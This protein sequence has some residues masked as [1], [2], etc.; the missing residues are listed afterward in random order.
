MCIKWLQGFR[1]L[2]FIMILSGSLSFAALPTPTEYEVK[3]V[4]LFNF[5]ELMTWPESFDNSNT[6][7]Q[8][9]VFGQNPFGNFLNQLEGKNINGRMLHFF[10]IKHD[11]TKTSYCQILFISRSEKG[12]LADILEY[13]QKYPILTVSDMDEFV[14]QGGMIQFYNR[15]NTVR[16]MFDPQTINE[17]GITVSEEI[18]S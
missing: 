18:I 13:T 9:C 8:I 4:Y 11:L 1:N 15:G 2:F 16:F 7:I 5:S 14:I 3:A 12:S 6:S 17:V 10:N